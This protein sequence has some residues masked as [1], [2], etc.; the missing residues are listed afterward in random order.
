[1]L[2]MTENNIEFAPVTLHVGAGTF[3]PVKTNDISSHD[4]HS[5]HFLISEDTIKKDNKAKKTTYQSFVLEQQALELY[6]L[7]QKCVK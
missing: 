2:K 7:L 4:M 6:N 1:M 3:L 5:E